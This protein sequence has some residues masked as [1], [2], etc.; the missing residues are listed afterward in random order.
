MST[1]LVLE[2]DAA[3]VGEALE[4]AG[5]DGDVVVLDSSPAS[6]ERLERMTPDPRLWYQIGDPEV[7]P[8]PDRFVD[9]VV[10]GRSPD[11]DRVLR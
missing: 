6:L 8:L 11:V 10:G 7:V 2:A 3:L 1:V 5:P 4:E 9:V